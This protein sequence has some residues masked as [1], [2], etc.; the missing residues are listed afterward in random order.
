M[1]MW[2]QVTVTKDQVP[3][4]VAING[5]MEMTLTPA[6]KRWPSCTD[7]ESSLVLDPISTVINAR[8]WKA[9]VTS[10]GTPADIVALVTGDEFPRRFEQTF[11]QGVVFGQITLPSIDASFLGP[12]ARKTTSVAARVRNGVLLLGLNYADSSHALTGNTEIL[13]DFARSNDVAGASTP[14]PSTSCSTSCT[15]A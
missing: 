14:M 9:T 6:F 11:R 4:V 13:Q 2:G 12:L 1:P 8:R 7:K 3:H 5:E 10:A 15:P